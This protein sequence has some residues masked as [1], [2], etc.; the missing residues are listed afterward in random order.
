MRD[1]ALERLWPRVLN[2]TG[3]L[4]GFLTVGLLLGGF[5]LQ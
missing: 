5:T 2:E 3:T 1:L 4:L